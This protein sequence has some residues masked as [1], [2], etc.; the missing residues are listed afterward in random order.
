MRPSQPDSKP[1]ATLLPALV[2]GG[3][4]ELSEA[5]QPVLD[6]YISAKL[7]ASLT[8]SAHTIRAYERHIRGF[9]RWS[10]L[11]PLLLRLGDRPGA[12]I[13]V[14]SDEAPSAKP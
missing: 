2:S 3:D 6:R 14:A 11:A 13:N 10:E 8:G 7:V 9:F 12:A 4:L 5:W 1:H